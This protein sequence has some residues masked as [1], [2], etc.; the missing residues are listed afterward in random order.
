MILIDRFRQ[1]LLDGTR[2]TIETLQAVPRDEQARFN[3]CLLESG[4]SSISAK[5]ES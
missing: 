2:R 1:P 3:H 4:A 5:G